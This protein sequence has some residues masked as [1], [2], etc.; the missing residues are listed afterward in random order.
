[1]IGGVGASSRLI[2]EFPGFGGGILGRI[3]YGCGIG[4]G[5]RVVGLGLVLFRVWVV[6]RIVVVFG[7]GIC[8]PCVA[9]FKWLGGSTGRV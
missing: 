6:G 3:D 8:G 2:V 9:G 7:L 5:C 4:S 1:M